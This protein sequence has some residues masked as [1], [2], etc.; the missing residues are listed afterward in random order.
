MYWQWRALHQ[1]F[2]QPTFHN[3]YQYL[4]ARFHQ[5]SGKIIRVV[6]KTT[7]EAQHLDSMAAFFRATGN[8]TT[9]QP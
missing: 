5:L 8:P 9:L 7:S 6:I 3:R 1:I 2:Y 4:W